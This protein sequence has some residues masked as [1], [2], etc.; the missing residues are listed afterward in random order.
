M[1]KFAIG[2]PV[3]EVRSC[4]FQSILLL[5]VG[6]SAHAFSR[7][8]LFLIIIL[9]QLLLYIKLQQIVANFKVE[10]TNIVAIVHNQVSNMDLSLSILQEHHSIQ[11]IR[12]SGHCPQLSLKATLSISAVDWLIGE[13][14]EDSANLKQFE[15]TVKAKL[16]RR[17]LLDSLDVCSLPVFTA[18]VDPRF[19]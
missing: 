18:V 15:S 13:S 12:C 1:S 16:T 8:L 4:N 17:W 14:S 7:Q 9:V 6:I 19:R 5:K 2:H 11:S 10:P 3:L